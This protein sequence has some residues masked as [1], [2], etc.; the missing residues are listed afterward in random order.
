[1][2][3]VAHQLLEQFTTAETSGQDTTYYANILAMPYIVNGSARGYH[4]AEPEDWRVKVQ[5]T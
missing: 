1:M 4:L 2:V 3:L 5:S